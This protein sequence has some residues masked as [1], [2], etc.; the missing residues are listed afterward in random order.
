M[1]VSEIKKAG[2]HIGAEYE[3][4]M[5]AIT[6]GL[7]S[8]LLPIMRDLPKGKA[9][10]MMAEF[11]AQF[12]A[13]APVYGSAKRIK[14]SRSESLRLAAGIDAG[15]DVST[16]GWNELLK[17]APKK[18]SGKGVRPPRVPAAIPETDA[19]TAATDKPATPTQYLRQQNAAMLAVAVPHKDGIAIALYDSIQATAAILAGIPK[20]E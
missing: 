17:A 12:A 9:A 1:N 13:N 10:T 16:G 3:E 8:K 7:V 14:V 2:A 15:L 18:A 11:W 19:D 4:A 5:A 6:G 20:E